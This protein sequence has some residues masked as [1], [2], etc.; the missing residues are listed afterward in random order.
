MTFRRWKRRQAIA[1]NRYRTAVGIIEVDSVDVIDAAKITD[2]EARRS[3][4]PSADAVIADLRG[5]DDLPIY[6]VRFHTV[7]RP[8]SARRSSPR[9][10]TS[11]TQTRRARVVGWRASTPRAVT[12]PGRPTCSRSIAAHAGRARRGP[13]RAARAG[14][15]RR[16]RLDVRKLKNLG[17]TISL[18]VGY[19]LSPRGEAFL[20]SPADIRAPATRVPGA[21]P[22]HPDQP[23]RDRRGGALGGVGRHPRQLE[24]GGH[25]SSEAARRRGV[26]DANAVDRQ[27]LGRRRSS[28]QAMR[29][30]TLRWPVAEEPGRLRVSPTLVIPLSELSWRFSRS[31]GPGGQHANTADT[32]ARCGSTSPGRRRSDRASGPVSRSGSGRRCAW[33]RPTSAR[34]PATATWPSH[35]LRSDCGSAL[36]SSHPGGH[37]AHRRERQTSP[38]GQATPSRSQGR[39]TASRRG[40]TAIHALFR[41]GWRIRPTVW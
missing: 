32:G 5:P 8:G 20:R 27:S 17:L 40:V 41:A 23:A 28:P 16:S 38:R 12:V 3:G 18:E 26:P 2:A 39:S 9:R 24:E 6:R 34:R 11:P 4:Y 22:A 13:G 1:G 37:E 21:R 15:R 25:R 10:P 29:R 36:R 19:R 14:A 35:A 33:S 7:A 31:G 30:S